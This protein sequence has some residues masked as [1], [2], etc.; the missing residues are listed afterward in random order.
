MSRECIEDTTFEKTDFTQTVLI[1]G[2]YE[3]CN[4]VQCNFAHTDLSSFHFS[5]C[6]FSDCNLSLVK[7]NNTAFKHVEFKQCK[8]L[9]VHFEHCNEFQF[10]VSFSYCLL[11]LSSFYKIRMKK[12]VFKEC[13]MQEIDFTETDLTEAVFNNCDLAGTVFEN[14]LLEKADLSN[15]YNYS[16][17]PE[18]NHIRKAKFS[19]AGLAGLLHGYDIEIF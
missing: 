19:S 3:N 8:L 2:Q 1:P 11:N 16:I 6:M 7:V 12:T 5:D 17:H 18:L 15:A 9:G 10:K 4:F 13:S 14:T